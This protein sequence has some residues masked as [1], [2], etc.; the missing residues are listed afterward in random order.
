MLKLNR[1][2]TEVV[3]VETYKIRISKSNFQPMFVYLYRV[4]F[5]T[6][7]DIYKAYSKGRHTSRIYAESA[8]VNYFL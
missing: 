7:L 3:S 5:L 1:S 4:S 8:L 2:L 6:T